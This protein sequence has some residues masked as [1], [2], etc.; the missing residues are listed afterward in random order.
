MNP[1]ISEK[2]KSRRLYRSVDDGDLIVELQRVVMHIERR[3]YIEML[4]CFSSFKQLPLVR[5]VDR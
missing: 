4:F 1:N 3:R 5:D 2:T